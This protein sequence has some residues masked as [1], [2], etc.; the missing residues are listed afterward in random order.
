MT[1]IL[2]TLHSN[3]DSLCAHKKKISYTVLILCLVSSFHDSDLWQ[4]RCIEAPGLGSNILFKKNDPTGVLS[5]QCKG[6]VIQLVCAFP[7]SFSDYV[8]GKYKAFVFYGFSAYIPSHTL[9]ITYIHKAL[10][11]LIKI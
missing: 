8:P 6:R 10:S 4:Q 9:I 1:E 2:Y 3:I 11:T 7:L 5:K